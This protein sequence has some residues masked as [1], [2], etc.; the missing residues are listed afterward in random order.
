L[1]AVWVTAVMYDKTGAVISGASSYRVGCLTADRILADILVRFCPQYVAAN[2]TIDAM[3][4][5]SHVA[6]QAVG[7]LGV[8]P[9]TGLHK[10]AWTGWGDFPRYEATIEDVLDLP[11]SSADLY[12]GASGAANAKSRLRTLTTTARGLATSSESA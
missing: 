8:Q 4:C 2:A 6:T 7:G 3:T 12:N 11:G 10:F 1:T 9:A 5:C